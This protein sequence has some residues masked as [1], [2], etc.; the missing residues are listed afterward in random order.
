MH[1]EFSLYNVPSLINIS[2]KKLTF[3]T[4]N[5]NIISHVHKLDESKCIQAYNQSHA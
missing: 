5:T 1:K 3:Q 2:E 4:K